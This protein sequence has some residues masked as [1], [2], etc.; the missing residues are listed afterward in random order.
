MIRALLCRLNIGHH[1]LVERNPTA[2]SDDAVLSAEGTTV[3][4]KAGFRPDI[5]HP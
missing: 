5:Q 3:G 4:V 2:G 1:W